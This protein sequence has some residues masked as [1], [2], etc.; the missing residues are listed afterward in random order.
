MSAAREMVKAAAPGAAVRPLARLAPAR[1]EGLGR[2]LAARL[3]N[4]WLPRAAW[5]LSRTG[6]PGLV[7]MAL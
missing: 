3:G 6:R 5:T 4:E 1:A 2:R 7:G